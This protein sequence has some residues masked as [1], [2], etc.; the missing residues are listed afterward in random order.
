MPVLFLIAY[1][2][3]AG[4][5]P[6][7]P[8]IQA[9]LDHVSADSLRGHLSF[10]ASDLLEGRGTPSRGLDL[11]AEYIAAQFRGAG[12]EPVGDD[13]YYQT[14]EMIEIEPPKNGFAM[15]IHGGERVIAVRSEEVTPRFHTALEI[16]GAGIYKLDGRDESAM[17]ELRPQDVAGK[18]VVTELPDF[19]GAIA[20][21]AV[22]RFGTLLNAIERAKPLLTLMLSRDGI[23]QLNTR[24]VMAEQGQSAERLRMVVRNPEVIQ[25]YES[26]RPGPAQ[27]ALTLHLP[28][29]MEARVKMRNVIGL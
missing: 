16:M 14:A 13:G 21:N 17:K 12:L 27:A 5:A 7:T 11:A 28:E 25:W 1:V 19:S 18:V 26:I 24:L 3:A 4:Q 22:H 10:I 8:Q 9:V 29:P 15:T 23:A 6:L 20:G 2:L